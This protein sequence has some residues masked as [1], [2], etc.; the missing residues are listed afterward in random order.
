ML[1]FIEHL[2]YNHDMNLD[3]I[4]K[5]LNKMSDDFH[6]IQG[7]LICYSQLKKDNIQT[8][9]DE[10]TGIIKFIERYPSLKKFE[11]SSENVIE[12][13]KEVAPK[14]KEQQTMKIKGITIFKNKNCKTWYT[15][16]RKD[17]K[18]YYISGKTQNEVA[19]KLRDKLNIIKK[20]KQVGITLNQWY[21][22]WLDLYKIGKVKDATLV[23]YK[24]IIKHIPNEIIEK[25]IKNIKID[26]I[27]N[28]LNNI[29]A[30]RQK[31]KV[32]EL[33]KAIFDKAEVHKIIKDNIIKMIEKPKH[34][35]EKG[36]AL[37]Q[38]EQKTFLNLC[39]KSKYK[40]IYKFILY[41]GL[42]VS[43]ALAITKND[44]NLKTKELTINKS[45]LQT[46]KISDCKNEQSN[47]TMPLFEPTIQLLNKIQINDNDRIF[48]YTYKTLQKDIKNII[49]NSTLP[50]ITI[51]DLRHSFI[52]NCQNENIPEHIIQSWVGHEIG[53]KVTKS[54]Y[55]HITKDANLF[56]INKL[57]QSKF[58]SNST[59]Q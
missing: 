10:E 52:T 19:E 44:I 23:D 21:L 51:H 11:K 25:E 20:E 32:Y 49:N 34:K 7:M 22:K 13:K 35:K 45:F 3:D 30:E 2:F 39:E 9:K 26:E 42:R 46:N 29:K 59:R 28:L 37:S 48:K 6:K 50:N 40:N 16:Y 55:T 17:G 57:N 54:V 58:Y 4:I 31:Q 38:E 33:L 41:Q 8:Y 18:Q 14:E 15:R 1:D 47:R 12:E 27:I 36:I 24:S 53:S 5:Q 56:N 43:E